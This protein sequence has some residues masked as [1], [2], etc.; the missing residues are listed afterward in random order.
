MLY[1]KLTFVLWSVS[2]VSLMLSD[3]LEYKINCSELARYAI[4]S[5]MAAL[6][7]DLLLVIF[8]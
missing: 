7:W 1:L 4:V 2:F 8:R 5:L 3:I 6:V